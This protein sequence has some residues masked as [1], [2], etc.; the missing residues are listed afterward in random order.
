M[1]FSYLNKT[2]NFSLLFTKRILAFVID[3]LI[4]IVYA[5]V[6]FFVSYKVND[7]WPFWHFLADSQLLS[8]AVSFITMTIPL[9]IYF[10][11]LECGQHTGTYGKR[12]LG[13]KV[14]SRTGEVAKYKQIVIRNA[15][16]FTPW[17]LAH[18]NI[19]W[20]LWNIEHALA[21]YAILF[22]PL[23]LVLIMLLWVMVDPLKRTL[24]EVFSN[25]ITINNPIKS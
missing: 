25:T 14:L 5:G 11:L 2:Q 8:H 10:V 17:E 1:V 12:L 15:I 19:H 24:Y 7:C 18:I 22:I 16:K 23:V 9:V 6:L 21:R 20:E 3:Y 4:L 13:I